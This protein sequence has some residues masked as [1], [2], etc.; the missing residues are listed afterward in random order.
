MN[1]KQWILSLKENTSSKELIQ[2]S[3]FMSMLPA[4]RQNKITHHIAFNRLKGARKWLCQKAIEI[5]IFYVDTVTQVAD[6]I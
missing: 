1:V 5:L 6:P 2:A 3:E 4:L